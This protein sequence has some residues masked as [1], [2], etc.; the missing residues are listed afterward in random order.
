MKCT[1]TAP[2]NSTRFS[3]ERPARCDKNMKKKELTFSSPLT[4]TQDSDCPN[5]GTRTTYPGRRT[6][7][8]TSL[9]KPTR[10]HA[11]VTQDY[12]QHYPLHSA[13]PH[14]NTHLLP[15]TTSSTTHFTPRAHTGT[16]T[17]YPGRRAALPTSFRQPTREPAPL[18]QDY[19]LHYPLHSAS[20]HGNPRQATPN[21]M[22]KWREDFF[23]FLR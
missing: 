22:N 21:V 16:R 1:Q 3:H 7:L 14:G 11:P 8:P 12:E 18:T 4:V 6:A 10:E 15:R 17:S 2:D 9:C 23:F 13:S 19:E 5:T 20:Q